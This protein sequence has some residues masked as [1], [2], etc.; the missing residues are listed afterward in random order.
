MALAKEADS[1]PSLLG[2]ELGVW[3][4]AGMSRAC[5]TVG[6]VGVGRGEHHR[7][8]GATRWEGK[9]GVLGFMMPASIRFHVCELGQVLSPLGMSLLSSV[10][11]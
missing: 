10:K 3:T 8:K 2:K 5:V 9:E 6:Q 4:V 1:C 7:E 11:W